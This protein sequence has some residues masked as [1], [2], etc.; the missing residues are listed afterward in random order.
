MNNPQAQII[1]TYVKE[2]TGK[3]QH[4]KQVTI[5]QNQSTIIVRVLRRAT[6]PTK[7]GYS[8]QILTARLG[9]I[10][11]AITITTFAFIFVK[12]VITI[13]FICR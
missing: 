6:H 8:L 11:I 4:C 2:T 7:P 10:D 9:P 5:L 12:L 13:G 1:V 3:K